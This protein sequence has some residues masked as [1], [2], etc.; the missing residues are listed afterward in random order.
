MPDPNEGT[1]DTLRKSEAGEELNEELEE[2][3][4]LRLAKE[5]IAKGKFTPLKALELELEPFEAGDIVEIPFE[6]YNKPLCCKDT[7]EVILKTMKGKQRQKERLLWMRE[8]GMIS[9]E[10]Y[11]RRIKKLEKGKEK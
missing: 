1:E 11:E 6:S 8:Q 3:K 7:A 2:A 9:F 10:E 4:D 5:A